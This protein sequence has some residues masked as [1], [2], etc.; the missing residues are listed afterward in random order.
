MGHIYLLDKIET[1][2]TLYTLG[3][4]KMEL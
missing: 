3:E 1:N 4:S 2:W